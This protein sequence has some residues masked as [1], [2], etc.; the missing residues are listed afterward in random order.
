MP[1]LGE[2]EKVLVNWIYSCAR[3]G[4]PKRK[5]DV[6]DS[7]KE[8]VQEL[9][10]ETP[11]IDNRPGDGFYKAFLKRHPDL[12]KRTPEAVSYASA[13]VS[14]ENIRSWFR[15]VEDLLRE[16]DGNLSEILK[17]PTRVING[18]E[19]CF[20]LCP[21]RGLVLAPKGTKDVYEVDLATA[22][23]NV[24]CMFSFTAAGATVPL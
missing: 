1:V 9:K 11:F 19:T 4:F 5:E 16:E 10:L 13:C 8:I 22:K 2:H 18:D 14:E 6:L 12:A 20:V 7:V 17:D 21:K 3:A 23:E 15:S 24:T